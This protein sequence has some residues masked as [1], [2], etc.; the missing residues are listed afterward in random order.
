MPTEELEKLKAE[1]AEHFASPEDVNVV[2]IARLEAIPLP[3]N[4]YLLHL[5]TPSSLKDLSPYSTSDP[6]RSDSYT[7][8]GFH[9]ASMMDFDLLNLSRHTSRSGTTFPATPPMHNALPHITPHPYDF[10]I[11]NVYPMPSSSHEHVP[12]QSYGASYA[13]PIPEK[14]LSF[15]DDDIFHDFTLYPT[16][17][18]WSEVSSIQPPESLWPDL[19]SQT[20]QDGSFSQRQSPS[21]EGWGSTSSAYFS[22][23]NVEPANDYPMANQYLTTDNFSYSSMMDV[24]HPNSQMQ[25]QSIRH[26]D[27]QHWP[28]EV[29]QIE[30][31]SQSRLHQAAPELT[32]QASPMTTSESTAD[33]WR[34]SRRS[35][36]GGICSSS[37]PSTDDETLQRSAIPNGVHQERLAH[38]DGDLNFVQ[39]ATYHQGSLLQRPPGNHANTSLDQPQNVERSFNHLLGLDDTDRSRAEVTP[40]RRASDVHIAVMGA[41]GV[42]KSTFISHLCRAANDKHGASPSVAS[43]YSFDHAGL[44]IYLVDTPGFNETTSTDAEV[45][46]EIAAWLESHL[47][48]NTPL[49]G[50]IYLHQVE[51][52]QR[53]DTAQR[54]LSTFN[55]MCARDALKNMVLATAIWHDVQLDTSQ[56]QSAADQ[57]LTHLV[58]SWYENGNDSEQSHLWEIA[59]YTSAAPTFFCEGLVNSRV[60]MD[61][62]MIH[63]SPS[64]E[65]WHE[66]M[67]VPIRK[68]DWTS[69]ADLHLTQRDHVYQTSA[70]LA[71]CRTVRQGHHDAPV[72]GADL[73]HGDCGLSREDIRRSA[74]QKLRPEPGTQIH[75]L[76]AEM[77]E[78]LEKG[79][80]DLNH[81]SEN[82]IEGSSEMF[83]RIREFYLKNGLSEQLPHEKRLFWISGKADSGKSTLMR[84][85]ANSEPVKKQLACSTETSQIPW[86]SA[87]LGFDFPSLWAFVKRCP[88]ARWIRAWL[89]RLAAGQG[90][91][92]SPTNAAC[93]AIATVSWKSY[94][95]GEIWTRL[96]TSNLPLLQVIASSPPLAKTAMGGLTAGVLLV[97]AS[98]LQRV[99]SV[100]L[101]IR[102][103][104]GPSFV[105]IHFAMSYIN[106]MYEKISSLRTCGWWQH[107]DGLLLFA[108]S[109]LELWVLGALHGYWKDY[110]E[111]TG[112]LIAYPR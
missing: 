2:D 14:R 41:T 16:S 18:T 30:S 12:E 58:D 49:S 78:N 24:Q 44:T 100:D 104:M 43:A 36:R 79:T 56:D 60:F 33:H 26:Q 77:F 31:I 37:T 35:A 15:P 75:G 19:T 108:S 86:Y 57:A 34:R 109:A 80:S 83:Q 9:T 69:R 72:D 13:E 25:Q 28:S 101:D 54:T 66:F 59:R 29:D 10:D 55:K 93:E 76:G 47:G 32:P 3:A 20:S 102:C 62:A 71:R 85:L 90:L 17:Q 61:G 42:G 82:G 81:A 105:A 87:P 39:S 84:Y 5:L 7:E 91:S 40:S 11:P 89:C 88:Q 94:A 92:E 96:T 4:D 98:L 48:R 51:G 65:A 21:T 50:I 46:H 67:A 112:M 97:V 6:P 52:L 22:G 68:L 110:Q 8:E 95:S 64:R 74:I 1:R 111:V 27:L 99:R 53:Q 107:L 45:L 106:L 23:S 63:R 38:A 103:I 73:W 70:H